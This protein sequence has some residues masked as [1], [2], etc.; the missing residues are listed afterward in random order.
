MRPVAINRGKD[1]LD[2]Y[3]QKY[4]GADGMVHISEALTDLLADLIQTAQAN[5]A[6]FDHSLMLGRLHAE[7]EMSPDYD[8]EN[9]L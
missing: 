9:P 8:E 3:A 2:Y 6:D 5:G 4:E 1:T 7:T